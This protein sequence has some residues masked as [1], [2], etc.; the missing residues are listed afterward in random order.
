MNKVQRIFRAIGRLTF[1]YKRV[2]RTLAYVLPAATYAGLVLRYAEVKGNRYAEKT[3]VCFVRGLFDKD[4]EQLQ[5]RLRDYSWLCVPTTMIGS[6][7]IK[8]L[9]NH[10]MDQTGYSEHIEDVDKWSKCIN[11]ASIFLHSVE[12]RY[13]SVACLDANIDYWQTY[14]FREAAKLHNLPFLVLSKENPVTVATVENYRT[15]Y[16]GFSFNGTAIACASASLLSVFQ[17]IKLIEKEHLWLT[18]FPRLDRYRAIDRTRH[19]KPI[20]VFLSFI[21]GY[22]L[23]SLADYETVLDVIRTAMEEL[24][25]TQIDKILIKTKNA[26]DSTAH[27][28]LPLIQDWIAKDS[29]VAV[30]HDA[31]L[32][33]CFSSAR[34]AI[35]A[36]SQSLAEALLTDVPVIV[37]Q[38]AIVEDRTQSFFTKEDSSDEICLYISETI[39]EFRMHVD[40]SLG[41]KS[42]GE[43]TDEFCRSRLEL[44]NRFVR[45]EPDRSSSTAVAEM[46]EHYVSPSPQTRPGTR[47][48]DDT[49]CVDRH[50]PN[51]SSG[52]W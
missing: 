45:F 6:P 44:V 21:Q 32:F 17:E 19:E 35:G 18:G 9:P 2:H 10:Y 27:R 30:T 22:G 15:R 46:I 41:R 20:I 3:I 4:I 38:W 13:N 47:C 7:Q 5:Y 11:F 48:P 50:P 14:A 42:S 16:R 29:R 34:F 8:Y 28:K 12:R 33:D 51:Q 26:V 1:R 24:K 49:A 37:P 36:N 39:E 40:K 23:R 52:P 43:Q 31:N 25:S